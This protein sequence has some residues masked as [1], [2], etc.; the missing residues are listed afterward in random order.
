MK[1]NL[2]YTALASAVAFALAVSGCGHHHHHN[3][4]DDNAA[5]EVEME[6]QVID[7]YLVQA[8]VCADLNRN[9]KC[10]DD[11]PFGTTG[12]KDGKFSIKSKVKDSLLENTPYECLIDGSCTSPLAF[13]ILAMSTSDTKNITLGKDSALTTPVLL[14]T[15]VFV[16]HEKP[17][18]C[19]SASCV[20]SS[21]RVTPFTTLTD[22]SLGSKTGGTDIYAVTEE[23][24]EDSFEQVADSLGVDPEVAKSDYNDTSKVTDETKKALIAG[25]VTVRAGLIPQNAE[26]AQ[27]RQAAEMTVED[28]VSTTETLKEDVQTIADNTSTDDLSG[29]ADA[30]DSYTDDSLKSIVKLA[31]HDSDEFKCGVTKRK[32]VYCW[33]ANSSGNLGD[34]A[35]FPKDKDG[36]PVENGYAVVD[37]FSATPVAVKVSED[38]LLSN[39][40]SIDAGN[41]HVC[42]VTYDGFVYCWGAN[43]Y[44]QAGTGSISKDTS[45]VFYAQKVVKGDQNVKGDYLKNI[46]SVTLA[47]NAS[48]A[49][50][51]AGEVYC[52]GENTVMQ[53]GAAH[54]DKEIK[55]AVGEKSLE[56]I[57]IGD[58]LKAIPYPVKVEFPATVARVN[59]LT[60]GLWTYCA[61]VENVDTTDR[62]NV[63][64]WGD[65]TRGVV[66]RNWMQYQKE[67]LEK[68]AG[69]LRFED[70]SD[71]ADPE[72]NL[73]WRWHIYDQGLEWHPLFG[74]PV[75]ALRTLYQDHWT[76]DTEYQSIDDLGMS[77]VAAMPEDLYDLDAWASSRKEVSEFLKGL[78]CGDDLSNCN[79][80]DFHVHYGYTD[81]NGE[82]KN[83]WIEDVWTREEVESGLADIPGTLTWMSFGLSYRYTTTRTTEFELNDVVRLGI[84]G[85]DSSLYLERKDEKDPQ[86]YTGSPCIWGLYNDAP[87]ADAFWTAAVPA[88]LDNKKVARLDMNPEG[89][90]SY[91]LTEGGQL[92]GL[93]DSEGNVYGIYG[94][95]DTAEDFVFSTWLED[96]E[97]D[98]N[99]RP[100]LFVQP[101]LKNVIDV[102]VGKRSVCATVKSPDSTTGTGTDL[103]CWGS[104]TF[105]QM[106]FDNGDGGFSY[107]DTAKQW[108]GYSAVNK[109]FDKATRMEKKPR[110]VDLTSAK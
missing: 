86:C 35:V 102:S 74:A 109:F 15:L 17:D 1:S 64:C 84:T 40:K 33:G 57:D 105:G 23:D 47:H 104:S 45:R 72:G 10:D 46:D 90:V 66:S 103:Y 13:R 27:E 79:V 54:P 58:F 50:T 34:P 71:L 80:S 14:S 6:G 94:I 21:S 101:A 97:L 92:Y 18:D 42:A 26:E 43:Y 108:T 65:D 60:A 85:F 38:T 70:Q 88:T 9:F 95:G 77:D 110:K 62:H 24:F 76:G 55:T 22:M 75:T 25:E 73:P 61:L 44:G 37:N 93:A 69:T 67:F 28:V 63:F 98:G 16:S 48:C 96:E 41:G 99:W 3:D 87:R 82:D 68:Y 19:A 83:G 78:P 12:D 107:T 29:I 31:G 8:R 100:Y 7:G 59:E 56:G 39:V 36:N 53:L 11:E 30:L 2:R 20:R 81:D 89:K 91:V 32:N 4:G 51:K 5:V 106:A 52:W 49:I